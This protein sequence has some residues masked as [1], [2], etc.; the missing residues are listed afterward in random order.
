MF[1]PTP[2]VSSF[3]TKT[4]CFNVQ[5]LWHRHEQHRGCRTELQLLLALITKEERS[6]TALVALQLHACWSNKTHQLMVEHCKAQWGAN[7][8]IRAMNNRLTC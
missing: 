7:L 4:C 3:T 6:N 2:D 8:A 1:D 5:L